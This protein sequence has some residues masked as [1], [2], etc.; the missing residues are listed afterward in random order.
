MSRQLQRLS[1]VFPIYN[2]E[3]TLPHLRAALE[4]WAASL[5]YDLEIVLVNDGS[6]DRSREMLDAW[7]AADPRLR[8]LHFSR[9]FGHQAA[10]TAGFD[11]ATG[12]AVVSLDADLQDPLEVV[13]RMIAA[14][15]EGCDI[16]F[17]RRTHRADETFLKKF[18][19]KIFYRLLRAASE[20]PLDVD[21]GD[22][23][24]L[25]R[26]AL[27]ALRGMREYHRYLRGMISWLGFRSTT[28][29]YERPGRVAGTTKYNWTRMARFAWNALL[30]FSTLPI[31]FIGALGVL[32]SLFGFA[33]GVYALWGKFIAGSTVPGW[34]GLAVLLAILG[35]V[36]LLALS[37]LGEYLARIYEQGKGRPI[38]V[39]DAVRGGERA[40]RARETP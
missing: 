20:A 25:S 16:V 11:H 28:V 1:L 29:A 37:I 38:Y 27:D 2:E 8:V 23:R 18:T 39:L 4:T 12:E 14:Y 35:G 32:T 5:R 33:Y 24:L 10:L 21:V 30:S 15:E 34:T 36:Q 26:K 17:A 40:E 22:F 9:N 19:A 3:E 7:A 31:R 13:S 6:R